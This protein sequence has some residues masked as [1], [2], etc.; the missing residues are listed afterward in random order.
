MWN[1]FKMTVKMSKNLN[2]FDTPNTRIQDLSL[3][4]LA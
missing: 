4:S 1:N 2:K 3:P